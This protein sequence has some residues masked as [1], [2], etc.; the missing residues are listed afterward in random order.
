MVL[1]LTQP[2]NDVKDKFTEILETAHILSMIDEYKPFVQE[3]LVLR[4]KGNI[5]FRPIYIW[6]AERE[7]ERV[8]ERE[9][10]RKSIM[11]LSQKR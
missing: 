9:R 6:T 7:R 8:R 11:V 3:I 1:S 5:L 2:S 4:F 10:E